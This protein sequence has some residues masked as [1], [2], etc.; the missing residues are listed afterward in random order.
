MKYLSLL[1]VCILCACSKDTKPTDKTIIPIAD[2][3][4]TGEILNLSDYAESVKYIPLETNDSV[5][6]ASIGSA[7]KQGNVYLVKNH[8]RGTKA[9]CFLFDKNGKFIRTIGKTGESPE[10]YT[11]IRSI[12]VRPNANTIFMDHREKC[13]EYDRN[14]QVIKYIRMPEC[15]DKMQHGETSSIND[16]TYLSL[17]TSPLHRYHKGI[18]FN[19]KGEEIKLIPNYFERE[20]SENGKGNWGSLDG[21]SYRFNNQIRLW[22]SWDDTIFTI[23]KNLDT[24]V[25]YRFDFGKHKV[26]MEWM[27]SIKEDYANVDYVYPTTIYESTRYLFFDFQCGRNAP[28]KFEYELEGVGQ[29]IRSKRILVNVSVYGLFDKNK[30]QLTLLNQPVKHKY[31]GFRN[32]LDGGPAFWPKY[33]SSKDEMVT[34]FMAEEFLEIYEQLPA[35]SPELK[36]VAEKLSSDDNPVLMVVKLK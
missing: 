32:D 23:N 4:G 21:K 7:Y 24:E 12:D 36:A 15:P 14:G 30:G 20:K 13:L 5:L 19:A 1:I 26:P 17:L 11:S 10:E 9:Q 34:W 22:R 2:A 3:V 16:S 29:G 31:L 27:E 33:I 25:V 35:P 8:Q 6:I 28:E 18:L